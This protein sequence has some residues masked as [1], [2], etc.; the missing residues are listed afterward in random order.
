M[1][2]DDER[3]TDVARSTASVS[4]DFKLESASSYRRKGC[5]QVHSPTVRCGRHRF[6]LSVWPCGNAQAK[7]NSVSVYVEVLQD[8]LWSKTWSVPDVKIEVTIRNSTDAAKSI[9]KVATHTFKQSKGNN[10]GWHDFW[11][12]TNMTIDGWLTECGE[13]WF[14]VSLEGDFLTAQ[15]LKPNMS[16][17]EQMWV[18]LKLTDMV[19]RAEGGEEFPCHRSILSTRSKVFERMFETDCM[20]TQDGQVLLS[21]SSADV[22]H[23]MLMHIYTGHLED[24]VDLIALLDLAHMHELVSLKQQCAKKLVTRMN[25]GCVLQTLRALHLHSGVCDQAKA[26]FDAAMEKLKSDRELLREYARLLASSP[27]QG[28]LASG[29]FELVLAGNDSLDRFVLP[30]VL[31]VQFG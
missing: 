25:E 14:E 28:Q 19:L 27:F 8:P 31:N 3:S 13:L 10:W 5:S 9:S 18:Q 29:I 11:P 7:D 20:E 2:T 17:S 22:V 15:P 4:F 6:C 30:A 12:R 16:V 1:V 23:A 24:G 26:C 21:G